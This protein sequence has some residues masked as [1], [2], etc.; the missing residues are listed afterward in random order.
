MIGK[1]ALALAGASALFGMGLALH[2][3]RYASELARCI[4]ESSV[5]PLVTPMIDMASAEYVL[6]RVER[7]PSDEVTVVLHTDGGSVTACV[8]IADA[9]RQFPR[10]TAIVPYMAISGGTLIAL[11]ARKLQMGRNAALSAVDPLILGQRARHVSKKNA[12]LHPVAQEYGAA[13][14]R[15]LEGTLRAHLRDEDRLQR[16]MK[17]FMGETAPHSW[18]IK[19]PEVQSLGLPVALAHPRWGEFVDG[20]RHMLDPAPEAL[21]GARHRRG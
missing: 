2:R 6:S 19:L 14:S 4:D 15:Y 7:M 9:I 16:A 20:Y 11:N 8:L 3:R 21:A 13:V 17:V 12:G 1:T 10:S 5:I 18:P